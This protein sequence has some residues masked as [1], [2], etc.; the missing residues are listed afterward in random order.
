M[1]PFV[2][3]SCFDY[4]QH[5]SVGAVY[6]RIPWSYIL[7]GV[8]HHCSWCAARRHISH[9]YLYHRSILRLLIKWKTTAERSRR[10]PAQTI[11]NADKADDIALLANTPA[12]A[13]TVLHSLERA[14]AG[15]GLHVNA[16]KTKYM[17]FNQRGNI[18]KLRSSSLKLV[19]K[20]TY[21]KKQCLINRDR[22]QYVTGKGM[23]S[24]R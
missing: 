16:H 15:I 4:I 9:I 8:F 19:D 3:L 1:H 22:Q 21:L 17:C 23:D 13:K 7:L 2:H 20:F 18:P 5:Y 14:A 12:H 10:Y 24:H 11:K 6:R